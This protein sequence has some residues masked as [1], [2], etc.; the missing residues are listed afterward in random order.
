M[1]DL[2]SIEEA[3]G[4]VFGDPGTESGSAPEIAKVVCGQPG[5]DRQN[6][7][8]TV[9]ADTVQPVLCGGC[10]GVLHCEHDPVTVSRREGTLA[11]PVLVE[12]EDCSRCGQTLNAN[13]RPLEP[14]D[15]GSLPVNVLEMLAGA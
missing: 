14:F 1:S 4:F 6:R 13:R 8:V 7:M 2:S 5:C 10:G 3:F 12:G 9:H 11:S 15:L